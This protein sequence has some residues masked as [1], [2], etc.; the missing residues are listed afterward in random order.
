MVVRD[1][2]TAMRSALWAGACLAVAFVG[3]Y[4]CVHESGG[5][6]ACLD[7]PQRLRRGVNPTGV[8]CGFTDSVYWAGIVIL[9]AG[10]LSSVAAAASAISTA[11]KAR[12]A[13]AHPNSRNN[14]VKAFGH[15]IDPMDPTTRWQL[16]PA[17]DWRPGPAGWHAGPS[18]AVPFVPP[19][20]HPEDMSS[21]SFARTNRLADDIALTPSSNLALLEPSP[22]FP[23]PPAWY[24]DPE[25][26]DAIRWWDGRAWGE[27]RIKP[28]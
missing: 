7:L 9:I 26:P 19:V 5:H 24:P 28:Q 1:R 23:P 12:G 16:D 20:R 4:M 25:R 21:V 18:V 6:D 14:G 2:T 8:N 27:S 22:A 15:A 11:M 13:N 17:T 3:L 10:A